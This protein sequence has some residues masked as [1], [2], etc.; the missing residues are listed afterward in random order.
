MKKILYN[1]IV[2]PIRI[3][4]ILAKFRFF[5]IMLSYYGPNFDIYLTSLQILEIFIFF[6]IIFK[7]H[8]Y[9]DPTQYFKLK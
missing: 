2:F 6:W 9:F 7:I 3:F 5:Y 1:W 4:L 8:N